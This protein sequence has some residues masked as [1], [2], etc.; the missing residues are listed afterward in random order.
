MPMTPTDEN[1]NFNGELS[2]SLVFRVDGTDKYL[3]P[4]AELSVHDREQIDNLWDTYGSF[5]VVAASGYQVANFGG[6]VV[7]GNATGLANDATNYT[8]T[9][10]IDGTPISVGVTG[11]LAQTFTALLG[12]VNGDLG[13]AGTMTIDAGNLKVTSATTGSTST[14][15]LTDG[16]LFAALTGFVSF[17]A[18]VVGVDPVADMLEAMM[19]ELLPNGTTYYS[20]YRYLI[21]II[22]AKPF[23][24]S[25]GTLRANATYWNGT[26]WVRT[27]DDTA[28]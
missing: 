25:G 20:T 17:D 28:V 23:V 13:P 16:T 3:V 7:G 9:F 21:Q 2:S 1:V 12:E 18:A 19:T 22:G 4:V 8:A 10:T 6:T 24:P 5:P 15:S 11:S 14:V 26:D 27:I